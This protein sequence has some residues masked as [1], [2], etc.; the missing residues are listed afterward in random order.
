MK[1]LQF[2]KKYFL[3]KTNN[4]NMIYFLFLILLIGLFIFLILCTDVVLG[5][6]LLNIVYYKQVLVIIC[7][8]FCLGVATYLLQEMTQ[9]K[10]ADTSILGIGNINLIVA[11]F[12][13]L[14]FNVANYQQSMNFLTNNSW[15]FML[16]SIL[17]IIVLFFISKNNKQFS[18][19]KMLFVG[20]VFNFFIIGLYYG[21]IN[22]VPANKKDYVYSYFYGEITIASDIQFIVA[23]IVLAVCL[24][25]TYAIKN[26]M[27]ILYTDYNI[28]KTLGIRSN[29]INLQVLIIIGLMCGV[30]FFL[31]GNIVLLGLLGAS[32]SSMI[33]KRKYNY[34]IISSGLISILIMFVAFYINNNIISELYPKFSNLTVYWF[35]II[36]V[37]YFIFLAFKENRK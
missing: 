23:Y 37:P 5:F 25:W 6:S 16:F 24:I 12:L 36:G 2:K 19:K 17:T 30:S 9:N 1:I 18:S 10:L 8:A 26:K 21:L 29:E 4:K 22:F 13:V 3:N 35:A 28:A 32:S 34:S 15:T 31:L 11:I 27:F 7:G 20:I 33:F 14:S